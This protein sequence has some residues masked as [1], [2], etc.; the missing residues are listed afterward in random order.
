MTCAFFPPLAALN[1]L[2]LLCL[3]SVAILCCC[4]FFFFQERDI[5]YISG[6]PETSSIDQTSLEL[7]DLTASFKC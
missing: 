4:V 5:L 1:T 6:Y 3:L 2:S 7:R